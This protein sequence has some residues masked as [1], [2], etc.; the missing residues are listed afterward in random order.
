MTSDHRITRLSYEESC[1][2]LQRLGYCGAGSDGEIPPIPD[3]LPQCDDDELG[4]SFFRTIVGDGEL[5]ENLT[6][7]RT[8]FGRSE[9]GPISFK[10][11]DLSESNLCWNNFNHVNFEDT[12][13]SGSDLRG[14]I[15]KNVKFVKT[16]LR[17][18]DLRHASFQACDFTNADMQG[19][20]MTRIRALR[21]RLSAEQVKAMDWR[22]FDGKLPPVG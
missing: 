22:Y 10:N 17:R 1:V 7:P 9:V 12:D 21:I 6:L 3:H 16:N 15:F 4:V 19:A 13:L 5:L 11:S 20:K 2:L 8:F 18:A 14:S